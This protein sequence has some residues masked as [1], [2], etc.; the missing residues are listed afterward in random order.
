MTPK[1]GAKLQLIFQ[2]SKYLQVFFM[3]PTTFRGFRSYGGV[4]VRGSRHK[5]AGSFHHKIPEI[6][7]IKQ[8]TSILNKIDVCLIIVWGAVVQYILCKLRYIG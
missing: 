6:S 5:Q 1:C 2:N 4:T 8:E 3:I 7:I